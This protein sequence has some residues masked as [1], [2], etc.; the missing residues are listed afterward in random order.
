[1]TLVLNKSYGGFSVP[2]AFV[3]KYHLDWDTV[4][5]IE[6]N[7]PRLVE[8]VRKHANSKGR[9]NSLALVEIPDDSTDY[10]INEYDGYESVIYVL[11]GKLYHA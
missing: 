11:N 2:S 7:D 5:E 10:E 1:M 3:S 6:R 9:L 4:D 8:F